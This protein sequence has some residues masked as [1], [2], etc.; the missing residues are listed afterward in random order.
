MSIEGVVV[1]SAIV[2]LPGIV[3]TLEQNVNRPTVP[4]NKNHMALPVV[5]SVKG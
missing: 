3:R 4:H 2:G 1:E 5:E